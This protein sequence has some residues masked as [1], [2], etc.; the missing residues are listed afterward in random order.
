MFSDT[1]RAVASLPPRSLL[2]LLR[3]RPQD[4]GACLVLQLFEDDA[5][6]VVAVA[7]GQVEA[8]TLAHVLQADVGV[9]WEVS[10]ALEDEEPAAAVVDR[11]ADLPRS[12]PPG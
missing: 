5:Q 1:G 6:A 8:Q 7:L 3:R 10:H 9:P 11:V 2:V 12:Q 4:P